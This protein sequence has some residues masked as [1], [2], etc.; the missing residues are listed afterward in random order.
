LQC[1][2]AQLKTYA[3][4][5]FELRSRIDRLLKAH[6]AQWRGHNNGISDA[7]ARLLADRSTLPDLSELS[8]TDNPLTDQGR[9]MLRERFGNGAEY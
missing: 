1:Q 9:S 3:S 6:G 4:E 2:Q 8:L 5:Y 7:G